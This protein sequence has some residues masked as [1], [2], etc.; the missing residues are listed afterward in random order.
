L[1]S[2]LGDVT[3]LGAAPAVD[4]LLAVTDESAAGDPIKAITV[5]QLFGT[6]FDD[7]TEGTGISGATNEI[8]EHQVSR[9]GGLYKTEIVI[10]L[11]S[12]N[13]G[14][15]AGDIIGK[16]DTANCHIGQI[17]AA[18]NGTIFAGRM[19]CLETP[20]TGD[21]DIDLYSATESTGTEDTAIAALTETQLC[22]SGNLTTASRI[23]LTTFPAADEYLY[24]V[25][26]TGDADATYTAGI[27]VI[28]LW[29]K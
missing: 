9:I 1:F 13:S 25:C 23:P 10:D 4:D 29:G 27:L 16:A 15:T 5:A 17:T 3:A 18:K 2:A 22:D 6:Y 21:D 28:E 24:L 12:L 8:C 26:Q 14:G 20:A 11:T 19:Y 7:M